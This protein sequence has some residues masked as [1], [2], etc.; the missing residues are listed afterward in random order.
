MKNIKDKVLHIKIIIYNVKDTC[1]RLVKIG[2]VK[3]RIRFGNKLLVCPEEM[4]ATYEYKDLGPEEN[5]ENLSRYF[6]ALD[7]A[8]NNEKIT[9]IAIAG[10][11]GSGKSSIIKSY[12]NK[13][14]ELKAVNISLANFCKNDEEGECKIIE[15]SQ[16]ELEKGILKQLFYKV[17]QRKIPQS[18]YRKLYKIK[19]RNIFAVTT[20]VFFF[21]LAGVMYFVTDVDKYVDKLLQNAEKNMH[22]ERNYVF[23]IGLGLVISSICMIAHIMWKFLTRIKIKEINVAEQ[24]V[25]STDN[26]ETENDSIF[27]KNLDEIVYFFEETGYKVV[28]VEDLD[29]FDNPEIFVSLREL[30]TILNQY[31]VIKNRIVF[32]YAIKDDMFTDKDRTKFF[33]YI[34]PVIPI[35]NSTNSGEKL[36]E[37]LQNKGGELKYDIS[38]EYITMISP[39][40]DDMRVLTNIY[41]EFLIYKQTLQ[42]EQELHLNDQLMFSLIVFKNLYPKDFADLQSERGIVK[43]AFDSKK[44]RLQEKQS[45]QLEKVNELED[46]YKK[47]TNEVLKNIKEL[48]LAML[49]VLVDMKGPVKQIVVDG[50]N[51][52]FIDIMQDEFDTEILNNSLIAYYY[53]PNGGQVSVSIN[54]NQ[55]LEIDNDYIERCRRIKKGIEKYK[56]DLQ[57]EMNSYN[58]EKQKLKAITFKELLEIPNELDLLPDRVKENE[59]LVFMLRNGYIDETYVDYMNHFHA[60]SITKWDMNFIL[61]VR[62]R[63]AEYFSYSLVKIQQVVDRLL[64]YEFQQKEIYNF[65]LLDYLLEHDCNSEKCDLFIKQL[66]D[67]Q[68]QSW[69]FIIE[70]LDRTPYVAI[71]IEK[72]GEKWNNMW[73]YILNIITL[74][75]ARKDAFFAMICENVAIENIIAMNAEGNITQFFV[76]HKDI[77]KRIQYVNNEKLIEVIGACEVKFVELDINEVDGE[78]L[79]KIFENDYYE[80]TYE[81]IASIALY[82]KPIEHDKLAKKNYTVLLDLAYEPLLNR[83]HEEFDVYID[84]IILGNES[85]TE[86]SLEATL[87]IIERTS[88][89]EKIKAII[90]KENVKLSDLSMCMFGYLEEYG[91]LLDVWNEWIKNN[92]LLPKWQNV[93]LYWE[94]FGIT[95]VL[96]SHIQDNVNDLLEKESEINYDPAMIN[97]LIQSDINTDALEKILCRLEECT[98]IL[99]FKNI[100]HDNLKMLIRKGYIKATPEKLT[101]L[102]EVYSNLVCDFVLNNKDDILLDLASYIFDIQD[103]EELICSD[104]LTDKE[105]LL[106]IECIDIEQINVKIA[107]VLRDL[108]VIISKNMFEVAWEKLEETMKYEL[109]INQISILSNNEISQKLGDL[110]REY[111]A[112]GD[113]GRRHDVKLFDTPYNRRLVA[114]LQKVGYLSSYKSVIKTGEDFII[115]ETIIEEYLVCK[116]RKA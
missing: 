3:F 56:A 116:V 85:N 11:Y 68:E 93:I 100:Q 97:E 39:Y 74:D 86:E 58:E 40:I 26:I 42:D 69:N 103:I 107:M 25:V 57:R 35:I 60:N 36:L 75:S 53:T 49:F 13:H 99:P 88:D 34:L 19:R 27:N 95:D 2:C 18:R 108:K 46:T 52:S 4:D 8:L 44:R 38:T 55:K 67:E 70:Y 6:N 5:L 83:I 64:P 17:N 84:K 111:Q 76:Q 110:S 105:K 43:D 47:L 24:A 94:Y 114:H 62:N 9:N 12:M 21:V 101:E 41:N 16:D 106:F 73:N 14:P 59:L 37:R 61:A 51:Y 96:I 65:D 71:F 30:N 54:G 7:W 79:H 32:I 90:R 78:L 28:F 92:K 10:P 20:M 15:P 98:F 29:R 66:A 115:H 1:I 102:K 48:K 80:L 63:K 89:N 113:R 81:M 82:N 87:G 104:N 23:A 109:L 31:E 45:E 77:L 22:L 50:R 91:E 112:L 72:L 33:E